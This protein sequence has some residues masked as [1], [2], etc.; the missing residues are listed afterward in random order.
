VPVTVLKI[1]NIPICAPTQ[2]DVVVLLSLTKDG[3]NE[4]LNICYTYA[5][6]W[7]YR[8]NARKC[9]V[10]VQSKNIR[11]SRDIQLRYG[12][13]QI[14]TVKEYKH[15]GITQCNNRRTPAS[16][17]VV[18]QKAR[19]ALFGLTECGIHSNGLNHITAVKLYTIIVLPRAFFACE[20]WNTITVSDMRHLKTTH[21]FCFK[22][23]QNLPRSTRS[24]MV[25]G[26]VGFTSMQT[27][28]DMHKRLFL[29]SL[30]RLQPEDT[31]FKLFI[32]RLYQHRNAITSLSKGFITDI[33][34]V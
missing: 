15:L 23:I 27:Y 11:Q 12:N 22:R 14:D 20:L 26:M 32:H 21:H 4:L 33:V 31:C 1:N 18:R 6:K 24:D 7:R 13:M 17:D 29:G 8:Y 9:V 30:C 5:H 34:K 25:K 28:K 16:A 19:G 2:A 3:L 10:L